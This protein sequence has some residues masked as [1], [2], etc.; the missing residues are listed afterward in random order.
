MD[1]FWVTGGNFAG[2]V[3]VAIENT[4]G[5]SI[6]ALT[7]SSAPLVGTVLYANAAPSCTVPECQAPA[8]ATLSANPFTYNA[9]LSWNSISGVTYDIYLVPQGDPA[10]LLRQRLLTRVLRH[11]LLLQGNPGALTQLS[12]YTF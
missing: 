8:L 11:L 4:F 12:N 9:T 2:E 3:R 10:R 6:Y 5:Q 7:T 1:L